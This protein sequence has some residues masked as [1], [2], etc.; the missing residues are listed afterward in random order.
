MFSS[1]DSKYFYEKDT[2]LA[3]RVLDDMFQEKE[4]LPMSTVRILSARQRLDYALF[5]TCRWWR[6]RWKDG[7]I[8][9]EKYA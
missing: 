8:Y 3:D 5:K 6:N 2:V 9:N 4:H 1:D 7:F